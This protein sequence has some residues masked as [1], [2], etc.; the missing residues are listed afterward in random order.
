[1]HKPPKEALHPKPEIGMKR[2]FIPKPLPDVYENIRLKLIRGHHDD[3]V[4]MGRTAVPSLFEALGEDSDH[5]HRIA[6]YSVDRG[7]EFNSRYYYARLLAAECREMGEKREFDPRKSLT[8]FICSGAEKMVKFMEET[9]A[10]LVREFE[11][12]RKGVK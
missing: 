10:K 6:H 5:L 4:R 3:L 7:L 1:M 12:E 2:P 8:H 11:K 9:N